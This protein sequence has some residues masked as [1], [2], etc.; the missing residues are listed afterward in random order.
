MEKEV[1]VMPH[2]EANIK[3]KAMQVYFNSEPKKNMSHAELFVDGYLRGYV[4]VVEKLTSIMDGQPNNKLRLEEIK[5]AF[6]IFS[7]KP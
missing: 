7:S 1:R 2:D 4:D 5:K 6:G 3:A